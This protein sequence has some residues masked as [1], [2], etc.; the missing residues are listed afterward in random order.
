MII[1]EEQ[2]VNVNSFTFVLFLWTTL[3]G[4]QTKN[5]IIKRI[6]FY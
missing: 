5:Y 6:Y 1:V 4:T 3:Y 2:Q